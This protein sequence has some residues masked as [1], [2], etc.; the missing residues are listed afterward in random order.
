MSGE[1]HGLSRTRI[2][3]I[4]KEMRK[5][6]KAKTAINYELYGGRGISVCD[7]WETSF[8]AFHDWAISHGYSD[9]LTIDR[10][11]VNGNYCPE[12]CR[13]VTL[14]TQE[15]N[16]RPRCSN[17]YGVSGITQRPGKKQ[18]SYRVTITVDGKILSVGTFKTFE[19]AK[20][21]RV[22][23]EKRYWGFHNNY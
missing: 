21:A 19:E 16:R 2:Y 8:L 3:K 17:K 14:K 18:V 23:A 12:N 10:I 5:R 7:E 4:W 13:W 9:D 15:R 1:Q 20:A 22:K 6:C 11:D